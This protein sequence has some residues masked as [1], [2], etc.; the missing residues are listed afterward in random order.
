MATVLEGIVPAASA[1]PVLGSSHAF[2]AWTFIARLRKVVWVWSG[3]FSM[4][5]FAASFLGFAVLRA[6]DS[7]GTS[8]VAG[9]VTAGVFGVASLLRFGPDSD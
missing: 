3:A 9:I 4:A 5:C 8:F 7:A 2:A 6:F 1:N